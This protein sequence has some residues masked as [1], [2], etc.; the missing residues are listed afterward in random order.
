MEI[1]I[2][3]KKYTQQSLDSDGLAPGMPPG[4]RVVFCPDQ[5]DSKEGTVLYQRLH[6]DCAES[7]FGNVIVKM[8]D[9]Q[10]IDGNCWLFREVGKPHIW[11]H[12]KTGRR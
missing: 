5:D 12:A 3:G 8:D 7:F 2:L 1:E 6:F 4:T 10:H 9:G 11:D